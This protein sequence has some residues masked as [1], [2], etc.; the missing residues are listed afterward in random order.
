MSVIDEPLVSVVIPC[1][2]HEEFLPDIL[3]SL[4][5]QDYSNI[6][7]LIC[8]DAS[9]DDSFRIIM[10]YKTRLERRFERVVILKNDTNC[11]VSQNLNKMLI[12]AK[13]EY[14]KSIASD[15][16][17]KVNTISSMVNYMKDN[18]EY[19]VAIC[20]G[21]KFLEN[22]HYPEID[23]I[24]KV[25]NEEPNFQQEGFLIR[26]SKCNQVFAPGAIL[27]KSVYDEF[28][29]YDENITVEDFEYWLRLIRSNKV[30][31]GYIPQ[32]LV[33]YRVNS[34]SMTSVVNTSDLINR[35]KNFFDAISK[36]YEKHSDAYDYT[37][38]C[39]IMLNRIIGERYFAVDNRLT[40]WEKILCGYW[41]KFLSSNSIPFFL[42]IKFRA[43]FIKCSIKKLL[44]V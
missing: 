27:R 17:L 20:N 18:P 43:K 12:R 22:Q 13:G 8:D 15:D 35:R 9:P 39:K 33:Y 14:I 19:A 28:G 10:E 44:K 40:E 6:E 36:S 25:Y 23:T 7:V 38:F 21:E 24:G 5:E 32:A 1:Y 42:M 3:Q 2:K 16:V 41:K 30:K 37:F 4:I 26:I 11:G 34:N 29:F 31:F